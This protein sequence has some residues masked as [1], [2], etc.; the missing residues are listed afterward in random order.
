MYEYLFQNIFPL[1]EETSGAAVRWQHIHGSGIEAVLV[2]MC[3]KE[4]SGLGHCLTSIDP[5]TTWRDHLHHVLIFCPVHFRRGIE[6]KFRNADCY[7]LML[8][9]PTATK[10]ACKKI[11]DT[12]SRH[13]LAAVREWAKHKE[14]SWILAGINPHFTKLEIKG[15]IEVVDLT[16]PTPPGEKRGFSSSGIN[17][18]PITL[19]APGRTQLGVDFEQERMKLDCEFEFKKLELESKFR[20]RGLEM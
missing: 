8:Q 6:Q 7:R 14:T 20:K 1:I 15:N 18:T 17:Q 4:A 9:L 10:D 19:D 13:R 12:L 16:Q 5:S 2:D 11:L 3:N